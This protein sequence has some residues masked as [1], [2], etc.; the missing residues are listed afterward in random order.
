MIRSARTTLGMLLRAARGYVRG[1]TESV[2]AIPPTMVPESIGT[3]VG[4]REIMAYSIGH[5]ST[6]I[7]FCGAI[8]G[9]E[10]GTAKLV[11]CLMAYLDARREW[12]ARFTFHCIPVLNPD[13]YAMALVRPDYAHG[14]RIGR[15][16]AN[17]ADLNRN[18]PTHSFAATSV[19][20]HGKRYAETTEVFCGATPGSE[21]EN[22]ALRTFLGAKNVSLLWMFH[23]VASEIMASHDAPTEAL[24]AL[25]AERTGLR[26]ATQDEWMA[27]GQTGMAKEW[28]EEN[29]IAYLESEAGERWGS[30]W[31]RQRPGIT[32]VLER[33]GESV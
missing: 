9:N 30:D 32:A 11:R 31:K 28:C 29:G 7:A 3:S 27:L 17:G 8:H 24:A 16:N 21:P 20:S 6:V 25:F 19:W 23:S 26:H 4:G 10:V 1:R 18:F 22:A 2:P 15:F 14:G 5:G 33:L 12:H 13:G